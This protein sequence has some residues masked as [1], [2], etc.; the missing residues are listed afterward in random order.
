MTKKLLQRFQLHTQ[1]SPRTNI[2]S[3]YF[4]FRQGQG[5][6][7]ITLCADNCVGSG[8]KRHENIC[9]LDR[10]AM[11]NLHLSLNNVSRGVNRQPHGLSIAIQFF[12]P[13]AYAHVVGELVLQMILLRNSILDRNRYVLIAKMSRCVESDLLFDLHPLTIARLYSLFLVA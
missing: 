13:A 12:E 3:S 11:R 4:L 9:S 8:E 10:P 2:S 1:A 5:Y 6:V 7:K